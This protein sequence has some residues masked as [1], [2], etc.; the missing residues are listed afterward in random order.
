MSETFK[1]GDTI[2][3]EYANGD[4]TIGKIFKINFDTIVQKEIKKPCTIHY[5]TISGTNIT[6]HEEFQF[7]EGEP[8]LLLLYKSIYYGPNSLNEFYDEHTPDIQCT[9]SDII[10]E[11]YKCSK[12][13]IIR[14]A[15]I[16]N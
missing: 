6:G 9:A 8:G 7:K 12:V 11:C 1:I 16:I 14:M 5:K 2:K 10:C 13:N 15:E 4:I 3:I